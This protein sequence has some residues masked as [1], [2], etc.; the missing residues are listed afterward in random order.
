VGAG[1]L[2]VV[3]HIPTEPIKKHVMDSVSVFETEGIYPVLGKGYDKQLDNFT[4]A[5]MLQNSF[6]INEDADIWD[7]TI[8]V[9][10]FWYPDSD[11]VNNLIQ[12]HKGNRDYSV[13]DYSRYWH[14]YLTVLKPMVYFTDYLGIRDINM[15]LQSILLIAAVFVI[16]RYLS[17]KYAIPFLAAMYFLH[18]GVILYSLQF[19]TIYDLTLIFSILTVLLF[20]KKAE[21]ERGIFWLLVIGIVTNY[22]DFLTYP[23]LTLG[24]VLT[25]FVCMQKEKT[26]QEKLR[27]VFLC[28]FGWGLGYAGM[29]AGKWILGSLITRK[30]LFAEALTQAQIRASS[31]ISGRAVGRIWPILKNLYFG[32]YGNEWLAVVSALCLAAAIIR[33]VRKKDR[34]AVLGLLPFL[35]IA[36]I[37]FCWY[38]VLSNHTAIHTFFT[39]RTLAVSVFAVMTMAVL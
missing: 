31:D 10:N 36:A 7:N 15:I 4:D 2:F 12:Y 5:L 1:A 21:W 26:W 13:G 34:Q 33:V 6:Y 25:L 8:S 18:P 38:V 23:A 32:F 9:Y 29:W 35:M 16:G 14:G 28:S 37:P 39:Y 19:S 3:F 24:I 27:T 30:N 17:W 20:R 11:P 22:M